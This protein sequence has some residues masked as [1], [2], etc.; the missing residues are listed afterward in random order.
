MNQNNRAKLSIAFFGTSDRS[1]PILE[2]LKEN[3]D[4]VVCV[5][6]K[7]KPVGRKQE[8]KDSEVK[9]WARENV[10]S[11][12]EIDSAKDPEIINSV[13]NTDLAIV[14]DFSFIIPASVINT[15]GLGMI[16]I[17]FSTLPTYRGA[18]P[19][20]QTIIN[21]DKNAG[22]TYYLLDKGM[23]TGKILYQLEYPLTQNETTGELYKVLFDTAAKQLPTVINEYV[24]GTLVP[25]PQDESKAT[26]CYSP[27]NPKSTHIQ[28]EDAKIDWN[29][30]TI[31]VERAVRAYNPWPIA[32]TTLIELE[33]A[34]ESR[35]SEKFKL[36]D[37]A[38]KNLKVKIHKA[39][40]VANMLEIEVLQIE[41]KNKASWKDFLNGYAITAS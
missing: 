23:D 31:H 26:Y 12:L 2:A 3:F 25:T 17:H 13:K 11:V 16:N 32:W 41:G 22:I 40:I 20:Q 19:V 30:T 5:T 18:S 1:I 4:L 34:S 7:A 37:G 36:K 15:P 33:T 8:L 39:R 28:K 24:N 9:S 14:A 27:T 35:L 29:K 10:I 38:A 21:G 6:K